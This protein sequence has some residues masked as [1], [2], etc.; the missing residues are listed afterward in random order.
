MQLDLQ[1]GRDGA[2]KNGQMDVID[3]A[4]LTSEGADE[5][6]QLDVIDKGKGKAYAALSRSRVTRLQ[7]MFGYQTSDFELFSSVVLLP[8]TS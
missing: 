6:G 4:A 2:E 1:S 3:S 8:S 5:R 7:T